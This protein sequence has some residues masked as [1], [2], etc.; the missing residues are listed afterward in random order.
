M[1]AEKQVSEPSPFLQNILES[2]MGGRQ[3]K[4]K[5]VAAEPAPEQKGGKKKGDNVSKENEDEE[6]E[7][8]EEE[9]EE[10]D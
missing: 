4:S 3:G 1:K 10:E 8:D 2:A 7:E 5:E 6:A 9:E